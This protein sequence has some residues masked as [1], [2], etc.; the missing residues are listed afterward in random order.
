MKAKTARDEKNDDL[1]TFL[2]QQDRVKSTFEKKYLERFAE[3][4]ERSIDLPGLSPVLIQKRQ[5]LE[6]IQQKLADERLQ[7]ERWKHEYENRRNII[8]QRNL[9]FAKQEA[10]NQA[11]NHFAQ[12]EIDNL[13]AKTK[14]EYEN[15]Q[16][17]EKQLSQLQDR[18]SSIQ[19]KK[20]RLLQEI[21]GLKPYAEFLE[22]TVLE[23]KTF[24]SPDAII[25]RFETLTN[26][27]ISSGTEL[28]EAM[29][30]TDSNQPR[31]ELDH[32]KSQVIE[33]SNRLTALKDE[34]A[35][36]AVQ[37]QYDQVTFLKTAE[38]NSEKEIE[39]ATIKSSVK[40]IC[41]RVITSQYEMRH[42]AIKLA[43]PTDLV[44]Q[45][46]IIQN[47]FLDLSTILDSYQ[48]ENHTRVNNGSNR[49]RRSDFVFDSSSNQKRSPKRPTTTQ[50]AGSPSKRPMTAPNFGSQGSK[51]AS[52]VTQ[53]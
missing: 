46:K 49:N 8:T 4:G 29:G 22:R 36:M 30:S 6:E 1:P 53:S 38:R 11:Y 17:F 14:K 39:Y 27:K 42:V 3:N 41:Q 10:E 7:Q 45:L 48:E 40:N 13:R 5:E 26:S 23:T 21:E 34:I 33:K 9:E 47:R 31:K 43:L 44:E 12:Q 50:N 37:N 18:E 24:E 20:A 52:F 2:T 25:Q 35:K 16:K 19:E 15:V 32:L 51:R 28:L